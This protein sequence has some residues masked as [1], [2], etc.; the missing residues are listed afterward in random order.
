VPVD[1][2]EY[3]CVQGYELV[4]GF[5]S[6]LSLVTLLT[7]SFQNTVCRRH[8]FFPSIPTVYVWYSSFLGFLCHHGKFQYASNGICYQITPYLFRALLRFAQVNNLIH[9]ERRRVKWSNSSNAED[10]SKRLDYSSL[11]NVISFANFS[12]SP[13]SPLKA[14]CED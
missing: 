4:I 8:F 12:S 3:T 9:P 13:P 5:K 7:F 2:P 6:R 10:H 1:Q 14:S 11:T